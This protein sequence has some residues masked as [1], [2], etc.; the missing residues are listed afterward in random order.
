MKLSG[1]KGDT[2]TFVLNGEWALLGKTKSL[3]IMI[4]FTEYLYSKSSVV[5]HYHSATI[6][7][8]L[9]NIKSHVQYHIHIL[10][11]TTNAT[12]TYCCTCW[13]ILDTTITALTGCSGSNYTLSLLQQ[14]IQSVQKFTY[15]F[16]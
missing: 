15:P 11:D 6:L 7:V 12:T 13:M 3:Q 4:I 16:S 5:I 9:I 1:E 10:N 14:L 2:S 8:S